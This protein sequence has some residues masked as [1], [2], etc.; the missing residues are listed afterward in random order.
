M[1]IKKKI[2]DFFYPKFCL[3]CGKESTYLCPDCFSK[4]EILKSPTC[5]YCNSR[6]F[7]GTICKKHKKRIKGIVSAVSYENKNIKKLINVFK[8]Q[9]VKELSKN[10]A[11]LILKFL[12]ENP[13]IEFFKNPL[14]F[15]IVPIPLH[16]RRLRWRGFNQ[17]EEIAKELSP[18]LK[19][20]MDAKI[21]IRKKYTKPQAILKGKNRTENIKGTFK[22]EKRKLKYIQK[23]KIILLDDVTTTLSTLEEAAKTLKENGVKE[24]WG[25]TLAK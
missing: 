17:A 23:K 11:F 5:S 16:K 8:Y 12:K 25:L 24:V 20:P 4:I 10:S 15:L 6:S 19:I 1:Q 14:G 7:N 18:L 21:I 22:I 3:I 9:F 2:L 13:E